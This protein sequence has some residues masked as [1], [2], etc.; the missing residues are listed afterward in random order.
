MI[1]NNFFRWLSLN[2]WSILLLAIASLITIPILTV[3]KSIFSDSAEIWNHLVET[4]L[5]SYIINTLWLMVGVTIGVLIIGV[6][7]GWL[8]TMSEFW[9][10]KIFDWLLL[11]PLAAPAYLLAYTY[12]NMLDYFGPV[13]TFLRTIFKWE[14][15]DDYWF[16]PIR[17]IWGAILMLILVLYPY[18]YLLAKVAFLEQ[19]T[20]TIEASRCLGCNPYQSFFAIALPLA[21][22]SIMAGLALALM[23]TLNDFGTVQYFGVDTFTTGIYRTWLGLG[24]RVAAA[25][26]AGYLM[27]FVLTLIIIERW[28]RNHARYYQTGNR[29]QASVKYKLKG[30][31]AILA[32]LACAIPVCFGF[33]IPIIYLF[34]LTFQTAEETINNDFNTLALNSFLIAIISSLLAIAISLIMAY[35]Q[36]LNPNIINITLVRVASMGYAIPGSVIAV[37]ILIPLGIFDNQIDQFMNDKFNIATGLILSGTIV[38]LIYAYLVRFL[39]VSFN[40]L[41]SSLEKIK[42]SLDDASRSLGNSTFITLIKIHTPLMWG[43]ILTAGMLV[44]VDVMKEL[45]ATLVMRPFNFDT[46]AIRVY[47]YASDERLTEAATPAL[48]IVLVGL[49]PVII[50]SYRHSIHLRIKRENS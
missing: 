49:I 38:A 46:L 17:N 33:L 13:Q 14:S 6:G 9:G 18:V 31:N 30:I 26:L 22:P 10:A 25:K 34:S 42:P 8:V 39:A 44:F 7:C 11:L 45:P 16:P 21:R 29:N 2:I 47:Q 23:E 3:T 12:T 48:A 27:L 19:S 24:E 20:S 28:S 40:T 4:V 43:S 35:G 36:R 15:I 1:N 50:L 41:E 32:F 37:G 5:Q